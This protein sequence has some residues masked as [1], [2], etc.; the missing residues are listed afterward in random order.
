MGNEDLKEE[1]KRLEEEEATAKAARMEKRE[2]RA[3]IKEIQ[4]KK[5]EMSFIGRLIKGNK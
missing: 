2:R 1:L 5:F 3:L 4:N